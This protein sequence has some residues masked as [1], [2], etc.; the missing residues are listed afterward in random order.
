LY[1]KGLKHNILNVSEMCDQC[2]NLTFHSKGC[3]IRKAGLGRLVENVNKTPSNVYILK[4][5][6]GENVVWDK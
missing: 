5:L 6:K 1:V 2:Y 3:E 4:E